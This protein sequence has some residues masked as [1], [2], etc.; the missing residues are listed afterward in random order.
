[1]SARSA[2]LAEHLETWVNRSFTSPQIV[3][4][5]EMVYA[6]F[7]TGADAYDMAT[8]A[9]EYRYTVPAGKIFLPSRVL[10]VVTD[11]NIT[12]HEFAGLGAAL[13]NGITVKMYDA[14]DNLLLDCLD[15][16]PI[17]TT[18]DFARIAGGDIGKVVTSAGVDPDTVVVRW[19]LFKTGFVPYLLEG[20]YFEIKTQDDMSGL[21]VFEAV[22]QGRLCPAP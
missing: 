12:Y 1:M 17:K 15:G 13:T 2:N 4:P 10:W 7:R 14:G 21:D 3:P 19:S 20:E 22:V 9:G 11:V 16:V 6:L 8:T 18:A 5:G